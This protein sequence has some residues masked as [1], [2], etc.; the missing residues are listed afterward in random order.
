[1]ANRTYKIRWGF[2]GIWL[3]AVLALSKYVDF[4]IFKTIVAF[5][6]SFCWYEIA[7]VLDKL[8]ANESLAPGGKNE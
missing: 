5:F 4:S 6:L 3:V 7:V 8:E 1:M 2:I